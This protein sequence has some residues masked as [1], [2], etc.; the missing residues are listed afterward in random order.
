[1]E[2]GKII[3]RKMWGDEHVNL[4]A[5]L[6]FSVN[7]FIGYLSWALYK[8]DLKRYLISDFENIIYYLNLM[9]IVK[10]EVLCSS[11]RQYQPLL[12]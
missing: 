9:A 12:G 10:I 5:L 6:S 4:D 11:I 1:M 7:F 2:G 8:Y 3:F